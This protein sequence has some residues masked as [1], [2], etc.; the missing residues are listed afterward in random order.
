LAKGLSAPSIG[1]LGEGSM[2][3]FLAG[4]FFFIESQVVAAVP[5]VAP[6][7]LQH[8]YHF[9]DRR[10]LSQR[11]SNAI[12]YESAPIGRSHAL[13]VGV[14]HYPLLNETLEPAET[15]VNR[16]KEW[17]KWNGHFDEIVTLTN[18]HVSNVNL[19]YFLRDYFPNRLEK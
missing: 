6:Q 14:S 16:L 7:Y 5:E 8:F 13:I 4:L 3:R 17:F 10:S 11:F 2:I 19:N 9:E 1:E 12:G 15:D 18:Q